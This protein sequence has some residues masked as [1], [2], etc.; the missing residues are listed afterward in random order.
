[1]SAEDGVG[2]M[3][4][5]E[6]HAL[7]EIIREPI[8]TLLMANPAAKEDVLFLLTRM[9][10]ELSPDLFHAIGHVRA[11]YTLAARRAQKSL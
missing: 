5:Q 4:G 3:T 6:R 7:D 2:A 1:M 11:A 8:R 9:L 10:P